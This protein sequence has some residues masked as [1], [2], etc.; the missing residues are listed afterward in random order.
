MSDPSQQR[1]NKEVEQFE[2]D[3][4]KGL[5]HPT[6]IRLVLSLEQGE[7]T[8]NELARLAGVAQ[9]NA[10]QH[11]AV[12]RRLGVLRTRR[13]GSRVYY[14]V[15]DRRTVEACELLRACAGDR[16]AKPQ[17]ILASP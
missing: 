15:A 6:R 10:S 16:L 3:Y 7:K 11:L 9:A 8:V 14:R 17:M 13:D 4:C 12:L 5:A 2:A 1:F